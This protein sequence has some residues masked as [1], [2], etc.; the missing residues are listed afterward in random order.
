VELPRPRQWSCGLC[1]LDNEPGASRC[2][3]CGAARDD[4]QAARVDEAGGDSAA[5]DAETSPLV[6]R[7]VSAG[8]REVEA[9]RNADLSAGSPA[10][11]K[12]EEKAEA[13][14]VA[15]EQAAAK[16]A[17]EGRDGAAAADREFGSAAKPLGREVWAGARRETLDLADLPEA[18]NSG[19]DALLGSLH[20]VFAHYAHGAAAGGAAEMRLEDV[21]A[22]NVASGTSPV[23]IAQGDTV[24]LRC[25]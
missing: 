17:A 15:A 13:A 2:L 10:P 8:E 12:T 19:F 25:H 24:I 18:R 20:H 23:T 16:L 1:T 22:F 4:Q 3:V 21:N 11:P 14:K 5:A 9:Q 7:Q 6:L